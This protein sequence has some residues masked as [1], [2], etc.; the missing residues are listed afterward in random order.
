M[1]QE[2]LNVSL[3]VNAL[4]VFA[5]SWGPFV[6][7]PW[8]LWLKSSAAFPKYMR[9]MRKAAKPIRY[10]FQYETSMSDT[11]LHTDEER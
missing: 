3:L 2:K 8:I 9:R 7:W 5:M 10:R 11:M 6:P 4:L 1:I